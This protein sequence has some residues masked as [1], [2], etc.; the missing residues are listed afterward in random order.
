MIRPPDSFSSPHSRRPPK[1]RTN[2]SID[3][4]VVLQTTVPHTFGLSL[5][6]LASPSTTCSSL[7]AEFCQQRGLVRQQ[8]LNAPRCTLGH[9][10]CA[11]LHSQTSAVVSVVDSVDPMSTGPVHVKTSCAWVMANDPLQASIFF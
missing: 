1:S 3:G 5:Q 4:W 11:F 6:C 10:Y 9:T 8:F 7:C 2:F